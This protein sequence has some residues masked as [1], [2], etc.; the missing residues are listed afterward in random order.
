MADLRR[1]DVAGPLLCLGLFLLNTIFFTL[2]LATVLFMFGVSVSAFHFPAAVLG[3][4]AFSFCRRKDSRRDVA[5]ALAVG[6]VVLAACILLSGYVDDW[7]WDG[8]SYH[9]GMT[10][11]L[12]WGWNPLRETFYQ[13][14][15]PYAFLDHCTATWYDAYPKATEL[16]GACLHSFTGNIETGKSVNLLAMASLFFLAWGMLAETG[17]FRHW[18]SAVCAGLLVLTPTNASQIF[19]FYNDG[20]LANMLLL[21]LIGLLYLTFYPGGERTALAGY[22]V[23]VSISLGFNIKFSAVLF[24]AVLCL[25]FFG[26]W[27]VG[28]LRSRGAAQG[29]RALGGRFCL[30]AAG[31]LSGVLLL[32]STSYVANTFRYHNPVYTMIGPGSTE[33]IT[34]QIPAVFRPMSHPVRFILSLFSR[35]NADLEL[36]AVE[37]KLPFTFDQEEFYA[38]ASCDVRTAGWG[39][40]FSGIFLISAAVIAVSLIRCRRSHPEIFRLSALL[41]LILAVSVLF[42]PGL[43]WARYFTALFDIPVAA[44]LFLFAW[45]NRRGGKGR[46]ACALLLTA[47]L[48]ANLAPSASY[49]LLLLKNAGQ[50]WE[51]L[52]ELKQ[53]TETRDVTLGYGGLGRFEGR[54]FNVFDAGITNFTF[55]DVAPEDSTGSVFQR[56]PL[57]YRAEN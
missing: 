23:F 8:N 27:A 14:A 9:K 32:G 40:F 20:F 55:E 6:L 19:T 43:C 34:S 17:L 37:L 50:N 26:F 29:A 13:F 22:A 18:Q 28:E 12:T 57:Y 45:W 44:L 39:V 52:E 49:S 31:V 46:L 48:A 25:T 21:C 54:M 1:R 7:S 42:I 24:F 15:Q 41:S 51:Q 33:I 2:V 53:L 30:L 5:V 36:S 16:F 47:L 56:Y 38:A 10:G 35:T 3:A 4:A 11:A